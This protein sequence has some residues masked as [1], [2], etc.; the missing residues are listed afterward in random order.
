M[1]IDYT[2]Q[3]PPECRDEIMRRSRGQTF[4]GPSKLYAKATCESQLVLL[5]KQSAWSR[6]NGAILV[7]ALDCVIMYAIAIAI[8]R[9]RWYEKASVL[10]MKKGKLLLQDFAVMIPSIP[11]D[12][13]D[14]NNSPDLLKA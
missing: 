5:G 13:E 1:L 3:F 7:V 10:D 9:L 8:L 6:S 12:K 4:F 11:V 14:Y 2:R